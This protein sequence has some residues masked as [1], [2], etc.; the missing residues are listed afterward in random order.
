MAHLHEPESFNRRSMT[1]QITPQS[2]ADV[3]LVDGP[4]AAATGSMSISWWHTEVAGGRAPQPVIREPRCTR[5]LVADVRAFWVA[6]AQRR[7]T[8]AG[9]AVTA[10]AAKASAAAALQRRARA[11]GQGA[12]R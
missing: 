8:Q 5:W 12:L 6:R 4:T 3:A 11:A 9:E 2:L 10:H 7:D 1:R